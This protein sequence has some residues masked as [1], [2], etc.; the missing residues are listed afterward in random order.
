M[1]SISHFNLIQQF[2]DSLK[3]QQLGSIK[4]WS[5]FMTIN[6]VYLNVW[7]RNRQIDINVRQ[8]KSWKDV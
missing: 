5:N 6:T 4:S 1:E 8:N 3:R 2:L 7:A